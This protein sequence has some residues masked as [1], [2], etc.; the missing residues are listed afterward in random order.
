MAK[1]DVPSWQPNLYAAVAVTLTTAT[2]A[3]SLR[4]AA[5]RMTKVPLWWD[6]FMCVGAFIFGIGWNVLLLVWAPYG[7]GKHLENIDLTPEQSL[8][9]SLLFCYLAELFYAASLA[10]SQ[11][12]V[13]AFYWRMFRTSNIKV[14]IITL[15]ASI[16]IWLILRTFLAVFLQAFWDKSI[17]NATC[18]INDS[19]F[20]FG[21]VLTH[22]VLDLAI[23]SLPVLQVRKLRLRTAQKVG[24]CAMFMFG[25]LVCVASVII[26][27]YSL[28]YN[29]KSA[30]ISFNVAPIM[31]WG[32][33]E[34][35]LAIVS[36][37]IPFQ[38][39][40][41]NTFSPSC[42]ACLPMLRPIFLRAFNRIFP[43]VSHGTSD[44]QLHSSRANQLA[45][46]SAMRTRTRHD[47]S[48]SMQELA[49]FDN[50]SSSEHDEEQGIV[51]G[52]GG[53]RVI[54][55]GNDKSARVTEVDVSPAVSGGILVR[56]ETLVEV[57]RAR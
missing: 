25:I 23:L 30:E 43:N 22:L 53:Q 38:T 6:D 3:I 24:V 50:D 21:T 52:A 1:L 34:V 26:L 54:I 44:K 7:F 35:N 51:H 48:E 20:F 12:A 11:Y 32:T 15:V 9:N 19:K 47:D 10:F 39:P 2:V 42:T 41:W 33:V 5:R 49:T 29:T 14:P 16:S 17:P 37:T 27:V 4:F 8:F 18:N 56:S 57:S 31:I 28:S 45:K 55:T 40:I 36:G 46:I 13:L